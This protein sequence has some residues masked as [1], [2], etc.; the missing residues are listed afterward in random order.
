MTSFM[1]LLRRASVSGSAAGC[2]AA[3]TAAARASG[4]GSTRYAPINAVTHCLWPRTAFSETGLSARFTLTGLAIHQA[5]AI[6]WGMLYEAL[7]ARPWR[8]DRSFAKPAQTL[9]CAAA[10]AAIAYAVDYHVV[11]KRLTPGF[12]AHLSRR[13][14]FYVYAALAA[15]LAAAAACRRE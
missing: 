3:I 11:P 13:S 6:F 4:E 14:M 5:S 8:T 12:E 10:T 7:L 2:A 15:G 1:N 9:A